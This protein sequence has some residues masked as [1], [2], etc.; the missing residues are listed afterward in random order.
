MT[1]MD[2][3]PLLAVDDDD[4][5]TDALPLRTAC[6]GVNGER[7]SKGTRMHTLAR[8]LYALVTLCKNL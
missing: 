1:D 3:A 5:E 4:D 7:Q 8:G 2:T 6:G